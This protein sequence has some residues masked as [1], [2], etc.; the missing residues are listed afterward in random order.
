M[1]TDPLG[2]DQPFP[3]IL[4]FSHRLTTRES[5]ISLSLWDHLQADVFPDLSMVPP[6][7]SPRWQAPFHVSGYCLEPS[8]RAH[9][10]TLF[11]STAG[12]PSSLCPSLELPVYKVHG[13]SPGQYPEPELD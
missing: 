13:W 4:G 10:W 3:R 8:A 6:K 1:P 9:C 7:P 5:A 11:T 2:H 12:R